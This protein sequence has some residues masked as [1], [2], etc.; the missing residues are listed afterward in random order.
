MGFFSMYTGLIYN[1]FFSKSLNIFGSQWFV[2]DDYDI[3]TLMRRKHVMLDPRNAYYDVPYP[4]GLDPVW[5][6]MWTFG[7]NNEYEQ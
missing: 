4:I 7:L 1:D 3:Q 2:P 5:Q 6:V